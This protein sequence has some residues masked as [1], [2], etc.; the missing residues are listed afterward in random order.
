MEVTQKGQDKRSYSALASKLLQT[1]ILKLHDDRTFIVRPGR[2]GRSL[3][4][5][6]FENA[7]LLP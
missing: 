3:L 7:L 2:T 6:T 4:P 1:P 5:A